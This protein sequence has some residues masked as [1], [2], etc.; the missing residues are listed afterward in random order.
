MHSTFWLILIYLAFCNCW[1]LTYVE[2]VV[3][4]EKAVN[5][6]VLSRIQQN[7]WGGL[8]AEQLLSINLNLF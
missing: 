4:E 1:S 3:V 5:F 6:R 2:K 8:S 7:S